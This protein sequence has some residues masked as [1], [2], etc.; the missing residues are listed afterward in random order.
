[1][2]WVHPCLPPSLDTYL[3]HREK[4]EFGK[5]RGMILSLY[6]RGGE[7]SNKMTEK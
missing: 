7:H 4:K 1:M 3:L 5:G 2:F 6:Q